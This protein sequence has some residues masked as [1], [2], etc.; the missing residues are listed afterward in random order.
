MMGSI[1]DGSHINSIFYDYGFI[2]D[3]QQQKIKYIFLW[4]MLMIIEVNKG[5]ESFLRW[6]SLINNAYVYCYAHLWDRGLQM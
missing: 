6:F 4:L 1:H 2:Q 3:V 5:K